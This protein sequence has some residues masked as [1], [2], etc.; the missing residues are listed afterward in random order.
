MIDDYFANKN[1]KLKTQLLDAIKELLTNNKMPDES[2]LSNWNVS[3]TSTTS[4]STNETEYRIFIYLNLIDGEVNAETVKDIECDF[5]DEKLTTMFEQLTAKQTLIGPD[6]SSVFS[7]KK[8]K[9]NHKTETLQKE[10]EIAKSKSNDMPIT[11]DIS[12]SPQPI[13]TNGGGSI[14][15]NKN[16]VSILTKINDYSKYIQRRFQTI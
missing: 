14:K 12:T 10:E 4:A 3:V 7:L 15:T 13:A 16:K 9:E 5:K 6:Q 1:A 8:N 11:N 2:D